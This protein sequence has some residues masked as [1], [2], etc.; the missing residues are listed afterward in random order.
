MIAYK[1]APARMTTSLEQI[2]QFLNNLS[3]CTYI[4]IQCSEKTF[5]CNLIKHMQEFS[6]G[7][8]CACVKRRGQQ[9]VLKYGV[10]NKKNQ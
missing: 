8:N 10:G 4:G 7:K 2:I 9:G 5:I 1:S 3:Y 6:T